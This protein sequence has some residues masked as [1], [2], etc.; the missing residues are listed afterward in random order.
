MVSNMKK[1]EPQAY[2]GDFNDILSQDEKVGVHPQPKN[3]LETFRKFVDD[4]GLMDVD[5]Q[6]SR[7]TWF[8]NSRNNFVTKERLDRVLVNWK[9]LQMYQ[10]VILKAAPAISSDHCALILETQPRGQIKKEFNFEAFWADHEECKE[11]IRNSWQ[12]DE[13]NRNCWNQFIRKRN[14]CKRELIEWSRQKFNRAD[15]E[16]ERMK[17]EIQELFPEN[18]TELIKR[19]P[20]SLINKKDHFVWPDR[21][22]GQYSVNL[23]TILQRRR[24]IQRRR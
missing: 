2:M 23:D 19:T 15:K 7:Y 6:E 11:V 18:I 8:S 12:Q 5:L 17:I 10:N 4:N 9:W 20:I 22:D 1:E 13:R 14:R 3:C 16:I 21:L 24:K